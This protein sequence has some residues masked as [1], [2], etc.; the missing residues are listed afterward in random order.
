MNQGRKLTEVSRELGIKLSTSKFIIK[1]FKKYGRIFRKKSSIDEEL[2][3]NSIDE[4]EKEVDRQ[5]ASNPEEKITYVYYPVYVYVPVNYEE[6]VAGP[7]CQL[8]NLNQ[9]STHY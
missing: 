2:S 8:A 6:L 1:S 9:F 4:S 5:P 7:T 3:P